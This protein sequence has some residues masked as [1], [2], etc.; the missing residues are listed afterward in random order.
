MGTFRNDELVGDHPMGQVVA[1]LR[2]IEPVDRVAV[3][4]LGREDVLALLEQRTGRAGAGREQLAEWLLSETDGN[5]FFVTEV[6]RHLE[7]T[8]RLDALDIAGTI[9]ASRAA[10]LPDSV[11]E[12]LA[13][14][15]ARLGTTAEDVL[16]TA[17]VIG[18]E[19]DLPLLGSVTGFDEAKLLGILAD[20]ASASL[21]RE[22]SDTPGRFVFVHALVQHAMLVLLG[23][24]RTASLHRRVAEQLEAGDVGRSL[25]ALA[26]HWLQATQVSDA[27]RARDWTRQAGEAAL[28]NLAPADAVGYLRMAIDLHDRVRD[29]D[30]LTRIDLLTSLGVAQRQ[31]SDPGYRETLLEACR[32]ALTAGDAERLAE[33][34]LANNI[35]TF[36]TFQGVD[37]ERVAMLEAAAEAGVRDPGRRAELLAT[38]ANELTYSGDL[39]RRRRLAAEALDVARSTG[40][41]PLRLRVLS[42]LSYALWLPHNLD[43]RLAL[44][45][46]SRPLAARLDDPMLRFW[47][48]LWNQRNLFQAGRIAESDLELQVFEEVAERLAQPA[49]LWRSLQKVAVRQL[50]AGD[51]GAA[52]E[53]VERAAALGDAAGAP[54]AGVYAK[55]QRVAVAWLRGTLGHLAERIDG[56]GPRPLSARASLALLFSSTDRHDDA[57]LVLDDV[58]GGALAQLPLDPAY[59]T[60][61]AWL[62]EAAIRLRHADAAAVLLEAVAPLA[63]QV[64][65]DGVVTVGGLWHYVGGLHLVLDEADHAVEWLEQSVAHH[66]EL[67]APF[68]EARSRHLL[69]RALRR[70]GVAGARSAAALE[71]ER[72]ATLA[73]HHGFAGVTRDLSA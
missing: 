34:A 43:E 59:V 26:H 45:E 2:R 29:P 62:A 58:A 60:S 9:G 42:H 61:V 51:H 25:D 64:G 11:R 12:V 22:I 57:R 21:V 63:H 55:S 66:R 24:A 32:L 37:A 41:A 19:F 54:E 10:L 47:T 33:G 16:A 8:G 71:W 65:F 5:A 53:L 49:L 70:R 39:D 50:L 20:A 38:L 14:R 72:A 4:G 27:A 69:G 35:G 31:A 28:A 13:A 3:E 1:A 46:E 18:A 73:A 68:F 36:S 44:T 15:I 30:V 56:R 52:A 48:A 6:V 17:A 23:P 7:E 40:D 67:G